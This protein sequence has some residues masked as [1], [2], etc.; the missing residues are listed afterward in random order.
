MLD[1]VGLGL[2]AVLA[3]LTV[4]VGLLLDLVDPGAVLLHPLLA[5]EVQLALVALVQ[6]A[7]AGF[8]HPAPKVDHRLIAN[9]AFY[10]KIEIYFHFFRERLET[11]LIWI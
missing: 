7:Q 2:E 9:S 1:Q 8:H 3:L 6:G 10:C 5:Q 4:D 11:S